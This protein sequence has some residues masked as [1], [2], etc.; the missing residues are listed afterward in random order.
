MAI[1]VFSPID[2]E[3]TSS[4]LSIDGDLAVDTNT[5]FVDASTNKVGIGATSPLHPL[6]VIGDAYIQTGSI[7]ISQGSYRIKN[8]SAGTQAIGF[9]S[10]GNFTFENVNVG[11]GTTSPGQKL[12]VEDT[13]GIKRA[14]VAA[15]STIQQTGSGLTINAPSGYHPLIVKHAGTELARINNSG[16]VLIGTTTDSGERL[17]VSGTARIE[18]DLSFSSQVGTWITSNVMADAI[19]WN[20]SYGVY[21]GSNV[22]GTHYLRGNGTFTTGGSTYNLWHS[23]NFTDNSSNWDTAYGWGDHASEGYLTSETYTAHED[24]STLSGTYGSTSN[25]TKIDQITVDSNGHITAIT[26]GSTGDI[27]GITAG[28]GLSGGGTSGTPTIS[29]VYLPAE[30]DRDVKPSTTDITSSIKAIKP[31]F[32]SFNGMTGSNGGAYLDMLAFD[33]YSD[34]SG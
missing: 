26:T 28:T 21:I 4:G 25:G 31:F 11:I 30:D 10:S 2:F 5:F 14:G 7:H 20:T 18:G 16:K 17:Q 33:T 8:A 9:P 32:T 29:S 24:T 1:K 13:I 23:G 34:S 19:G 6:H 22:G 27:N 12:E 3:D 15:T